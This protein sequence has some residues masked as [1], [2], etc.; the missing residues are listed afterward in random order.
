MVLH[1]ISSETLPEKLAEYS[2]YCIKLYEAERDQIMVKHNK[3]ISA[4]K[5][6]SITGI[7]LTSGLGLALVN[8][9]ST[10]SMS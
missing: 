8:L 6:T 1:N 3:I 10:A 4:N 2:Q 7:A 5:S 9:L